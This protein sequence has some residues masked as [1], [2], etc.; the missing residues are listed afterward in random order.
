MPLLVGHLGDRHLAAEAGIVDQHI[1]MAERGQRCIAQAID[2]GLL[3]HIAQHGGGPFAA[4]LGRDPVRRLA[5]TAL[6]EVRDQHPRAFFGS[7]LGDCKADAGARRGGH[8][9]GLA[10]KQV[11]RRRI[12]GRQAHASPLGSRGRPRPRSA[13]RLR[14]IWLVPP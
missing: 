7:A 3:R 6:V 12:G 1:D 8:H 11:A 13:I 10:R 9:H 5:Q 4:D 2:I 14:W